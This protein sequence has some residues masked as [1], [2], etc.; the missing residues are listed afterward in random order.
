M[1]S[2]D[3]T[4]GHQLVAWTFTNSTGQTVVINSGT[5]DAT[6]LSTGSAIDATASFTP[7]SLDLDATAAATTAVS[8]DATGDYHLVVNYKPGLAVAVDLD[9]EVVLPGGCV[10]S[11]TT[12]P[13]TT[14]VD[15]GSGGLPPTGSQAAEVAVAA[16]VA[17]GL[18]ALLLLARRRRPVL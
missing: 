4:T 7:T 8:G 15:N 10:A 9:Q 6:G 5:V 13:S 3:A 12:S 11:T 18:G 1:V 2:C 16:G 17:L 14:A